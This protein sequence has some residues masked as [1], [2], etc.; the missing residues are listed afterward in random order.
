MECTAK[1]N[2]F[3]EIKFE[4]HAIEIFCKY[5]GLSNHSRPI[6]SHE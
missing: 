2:E 5:I 3:D 4:I 1:R 6:E